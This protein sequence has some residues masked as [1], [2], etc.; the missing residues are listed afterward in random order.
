MK[1][2]SGSLLSILCL[3]ASTS[4][5]GQILSPSVEEKQ[6][7]TQAK[8]ASSNMNDPKISNEPDQTD[9]FAI[10]LDNSEEEEQVEIENLEATQKRME[11]AKELKL[12]QEMATKAETQ[13]SS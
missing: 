11:A 3:I 6:I 12:K 10:P 2:I 5:A 9:V 13:A 4:Y 7:P 8:S 1:Q